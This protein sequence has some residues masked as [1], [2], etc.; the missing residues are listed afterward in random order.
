MY[1]GKNG[2]PFRSGGTSACDSGGD[3]YNDD[4]IGGDPVPSPRLGL[5]MPR[6]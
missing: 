5:A 3:A 2:Y 4:D 6:V 1:P